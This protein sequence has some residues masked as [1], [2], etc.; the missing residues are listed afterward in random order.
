MSNPSRT[1]IL[2][3]TPFTQ[4]I[5]TTLPNTP[6]TQLQTAQQMSPNAVMLNSPSFSPELLNTVAPMANY[7]STNYQPTPAVQLTQLAPSPTMMNSNSAPVYQSP[8]MLLSPSGVP[9]QTQGFSLPR[10]S[11][12][13]QMQQTYSPENPSMYSPQANGSQP[14]MAPRYSP[15]VQMAI[16]SA[17]Q[18]PSMSIPAFSASA[19]TQPPPSTRINYASNMVGQP[20]D[21][22][23]DDS[24][25]SGDNSLDYPDWEIIV[26]KMAEMGT[27][28]QLASFFQR[29]ANHRL[30]SKR[31]A[32]D[33]RYFWKVLAPYKG[34]VQSELYTR[35]NI[36]RLETGETIAVPIHAP[37]IPMEEL[38]EVADAP[39]RY[40]LIKFIIDISDDPTANTGSVHSNLI[41]IDME[42]KE[43]VRFEPMYDAELTPVID[44][45]V[46]QFFATHLP[47]FSYRLSDEHPQLQRTESCPSKGM[48]A[49]YTLK[50][51][52]LLV[53]GID[54]QMS[55]SPEDEEMKIMRFAE[56]IEREYGPLPV[57]DGEVA[58]TAEMIRHQGEHGLSIG[59]STGGYGGYPSPYASP[60]GYGVPPVIV[61]PPMYT[62]PYSPGYSLAY[63][64]Y[65]RGP[66][67]GR[68]PGR[69]FG[70][71]RHFGLGGDELNM[72]EETYQRL[73]NAHNKAYEMMHHKNFTP[74]KESTIM[75][76]VT[77]YGCG[78][79]GCKSSPPPGEYGYWSR[80]EYGRVHWKSA[81]IGDS[82]NLKRMSM[83]PISHETSK[84]ISDPRMQNVPMKRREET[85]CGCA[86]ARREHG[87]N[88]RPSTWSPQTQ[89]LAGAGIGAGA[90]LL[91]GGGVGGALVGGLAGGAGGY[92]L[93][94]ANRESRPSGRRW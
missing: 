88:L 56:A 93:G 25:V 36:E 8:P 86:M 21:P 66:R 60:Y 19:L 44:A 42:L 27:C 63:Y 89:T 6:M 52:M 5:N 10:T 58:S 54:A 34:L 3:P 17:P 50:K 32:L 62:Q 38:A 23:D 13:V 74:G 65:G 16:N 22:S 45:M 24:D 87:L 39:T 92:L 1:A 59:F 4:A 41:W 2:T 55:G 76:S 43:V 78:C 53:N 33:G 80:D 67:F 20:Q 48:C 94:R 18:Q 57:E 68:R 46:Q 79:D 61:P 7:Q 11:Q 15:E 30:S 85:G 64:G 75:R 82:T 49:A 90:G 69:G 26:R 40:R 73:T 91:L 29:Y 47:K 37:K 31:C 9:V 14:T 12:L 84:T 71:R 81:N 83:S 70:S 35:L 77:E 51:A 28:E 72:D